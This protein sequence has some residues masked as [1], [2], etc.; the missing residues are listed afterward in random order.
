MKRTRTVISDHQG[1]VGVMGRESCGG[2]RGVRRYKSWRL[3]CTRDVRIMIRAAAE[4]LEIDGFAMNVLLP[5][6]ELQGLRT[7]HLDF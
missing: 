7:L 4:R 3:R 2:S 5:D 6:T 1:V